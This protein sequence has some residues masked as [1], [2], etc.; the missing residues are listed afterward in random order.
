MGVGV[1]M[2]LERELEMCLRKARKA[3]CGGPRIFSLLSLQLDAASF[4]GTGSSVTQPLLQLMGA[5]SEHVFLLKC[6]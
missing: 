2:R 3:Q 5:P 6:S 1:A 4:V